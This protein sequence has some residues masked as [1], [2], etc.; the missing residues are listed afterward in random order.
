M[1]ELKD[2]GA[3]RAVLAGTAH[4]SDAFLDVDFQLG[5][6]TFT[7][8][9]NQ[10]IWKCIKSIRDENLESIIDVPLIR[11]KARELGF[12]H[13]VENPEELNYIKKILG[14]VVETSN[15]RKFAAIIRK[16]EIARLLNDQLEEAQ[17]EIGRIKG[18]ESIDTILSIAQNKVFDFSDLLINDEEG[19]VHVSQG[20]L[21]YYDYLKDNPRELVGISTGFPIWD[22]F[23][24]GLRRKTVSLIGARAGLG[25][26]M[27]SDN[28][29][30]HIAGKTKIPTLYLDTEMA[31][32]G[33][34]H[35]LWANVSGIP[36]K[37]IET[38][39]FS[40]NDIKTDKVKQAVDYIN[41]IPYYY[42][43]I[44]GKP[45]EEILSYI[46]R[47]LIKEVGYNTDGKLNDCVVIYD[48]LKMMSSAGLSSDMKEYQ[49]L[50]FQMTGLHNFT[51]KFDI[52]ILSFVQL[53]RDGIDKE[54][55]EALAQSDRIGWLASNA[56]IYK[57]KSEDEMGP[58]SQ[59][60]N[61]KIILIK[62]RYGPINGYNEY[63]NMKFE[64]EYARI[65]EGP[66]SSK[67][68]I[69]KPNEF[70]VQKDNDE[71]VSFNDNKVRKK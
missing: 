31:L 13:I 1:G 10:I 47:W 49:I 54:G 36:M 22:S 67:I 5:A 24:G 32:D 12:E 14:F 39:K 41:S 16:F 2:L 18:N 27:I 48:Y 15:V 40:K 64:G 57:L 38:G 20:A 59:Y 68:P 37:V 58:T 71:N 42:A 21:E 17:D 34:W 66:L 8:D 70:E 55:L 69:N 46:R 61:R 45:F 29:A 53:N 43:N 3:E 30:L 33:H 4:S 28:V 50:G 60:G 26:S 63:I 52:P 19:I 65:T 56:S 44:S 35:R 6:E 51:V 62:N 7:D 23:I 9:T 11:S 25:K